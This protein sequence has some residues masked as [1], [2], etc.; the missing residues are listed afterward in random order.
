MRLGQCDQPGEACANQDEGG[1][2]ICCTNMLYKLMMGT[3]P[4]HGPLRLCQCN[5]LGEAIGPVGSGQ[6]DN[7]MVSSPFT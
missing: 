1:G 7:C 2:V 3:G 6:R 4:Q 5:Q